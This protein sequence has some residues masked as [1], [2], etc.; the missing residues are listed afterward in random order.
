MK[1]TDEQVLNRL[2][3]MSV[4]DLIEDPIE[5]IPFHQQVLVTMCQ[6]GPHTRSNINVVAT[7]I[8][9]IIAISRNKAMNLYTQ[10]RLHRNLHFTT[11][12]LHLY[13]VCL[14]LYCQMGLDKDSKLLPI[15]FVSACTRHFISADRKVIV[16]NYIEGQDNHELDLVKAKIVTSC[17]EGLLEYFKFENS[18]R[19]QTSDRKK[20]PCIQTGFTRTNAH[21]YKHNRATQ[22]GH[23]HPSLIVSYLGGASKSCRRAL[24]CAIAMANR[25][26]DQSPC[27]FKIDKEAPSPYR[28]W[29]R[30]KY[31]RF[32]GFST[33]PEDTVIT[34]FLNHEANSIMSNFRIN[35]HYDNLN[36]PLPCMSAVVTTSLCLSRSETFF[37]TTPELN[38]LLDS[39]GYMDYMPYGQVSYSRKACNDSSTR[40]D[41]MEYQLSIKEDGL[42]DVRRAIGEALTEIDGPTNYLNTYD[43]L[44]GLQFENIVSAINEY[45]LRQKALG[46]AILDRKKDVYR[47]FRTSMGNMVCA[48]IHDAMELYSSTDQEYDWSFECFDVD[49]LQDLVQVPDPHSTFQG[50]TI[51]IQAAYDKMVS[52]IM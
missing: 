34:N 46:K 8:T 19:T 32:F 10:D 12:V 4:Q 7:K 39:M 20:H 3:R 30:E 15:T 24:G 18:K 45:N 25:L 50:P 43:N 16:Y 44:F 51:K 11:S 31:H 14:R 37:N 6:S 29:L 22:L 41:L 52:T 33:S 40:H 38:E 9:E 36:D 42:H 48:Q 35:P 21:Q 1:S 5:E 27:S 2:R 26:V 47:D 13:F 17:Q 23:I 49:G 28:A